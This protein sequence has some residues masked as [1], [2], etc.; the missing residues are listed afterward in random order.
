M[1][2]SFCVLNTTRVA[3]GVAY[4]YAM[5][6]IVQSPHLRTELVMSQLAAGC[7]GGTDRPQ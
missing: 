4:L 6:S 2:S 5:S 7:D 1:S 3:T